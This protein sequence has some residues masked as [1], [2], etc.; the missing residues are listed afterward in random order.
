MVRQ[1][2]RGGGRYCRRRVGLVLHIR[3]GW[4]CLGTPYFALGLRG[5]WRVDARLDVLGYIS[6]DR[7]L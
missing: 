1:A 5:G 7:G 3:S 6:F 2:G 4:R